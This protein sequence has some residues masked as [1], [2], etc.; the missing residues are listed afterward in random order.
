M[1]FKITLRKCST[2]SV[3]SVI[4]TTDNTDEVGKSHALHQTQ[5]HEKQSI[6]S[7]LFKK[8]LISATIV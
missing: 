5:E 8:G 3:I 7:S 4:F 2:Q 6:L 1:S